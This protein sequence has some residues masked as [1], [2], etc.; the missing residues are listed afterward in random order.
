[1]KDILEVIALILF[2][3]TAAALYNYF[4]RDKELIKYNRKFKNIFKRL[5]NFDI[6][7]LRAN[8]LALRKSYEEQKM[9]LNKDFKNT[10]QY[11]VNSIVDDLIVADSQWRE[12]VSKN[13]SKK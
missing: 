7:Q 1:M 6:E 13:K 12:L 4:N 11:K 2:I 10:F 9:S 5:K 8:H 3:P